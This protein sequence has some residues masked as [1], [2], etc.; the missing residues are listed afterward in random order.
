MGG[1]RFTL[2]DKG[3]AMID[4]DL[5]GELE[6]F[7]DNVKRFIDTEI[8][9][10]YD[11]WEKAEIFPREIWNKLGEQGLLSVDTPE[12]YGGFE[13]NFLFS[14]VIIEEFSRANCNGLGVSLS[15]HSD[16]VA[17]YILNHGSEEQKK[18]YLPKMVSGECVGAIAMTEPAAG[19]D[20]QGIRTIAR[21][22]GDSYIINGSK[23][24][25]TNG[26]H[27]DVVIVVARTNL[28]VSGSKGTSLFLIDAD[29]PG[30]KRGQNLDKVGLHCSDTSEL[31]FEDLRV[32]ASAC[33]GAVDT[34][35][36][37]MMNEL[38]RERLTLAVGAVANAEGVM[39][40]TSQYVKERQA[41]GRPVAMLQNTRFK[42]AEMATDVRIHR[43]FV[44][45]CCELFRQGKL[46]NTTV[47]MAKLGTTEMQGRIV[48]GC[49]QLHGGYGYMTEYGV[50][51]AFVD[52]RVQRIYGGTSEIMKELI[53]RQVL[54]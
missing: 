27:A 28:D 12:E 37:I 3:M 38:P 20:L 29:N 18:K 4:E 19:S 16:I 1:S 52:A 15:V 42:M 21:K 44:N 46:D 5:K 32:P 25:I 34:G 10:H 49:L 26:Q 40:M 39:A 48:D 23:I 54:A 11:K 36:H 17:P 45:E 2:K 41:F 24:F 31:F 30:F 47:S 14:M 13:T 50:S 22:D 51:R 8:L 43:S 35:F 9:P 53:S 33:L 7:R 6:L